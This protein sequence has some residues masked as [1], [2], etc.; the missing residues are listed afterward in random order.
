MREIILIS[1]LGPDQPN[2][3]TRLMQ[4]LSV[5]SLQILDVGQAVIHNQ[6]TL[7][8]VVASENE[9]AT[10]LVMKEIL[11]LAH[12]IGLTVRFKPIS[13]AEYDQWVSEGGRTRYIVTALAPELT[14]AHL[15]AVTQIVSSQGFN[16]ET[17]TRLSGRVDLEKDSTLPRR[18]CVQF[19]LSSGPTLDAQAMR[20]A[21][22]LLSSELNIDVAVQED[23]AYRR[24]R[25][26]VCFD[27]DSTLIEQ[28]VIDELALEAGVGEQVAEIT[29]RA[30]QG[31][32]DF[33]Q[34]FRARVALLKGLDAS[35]LPKIAERLTITEG[36]E[37]LISTLKAL[38][39]KTAILSGGFQ[40]FAEYLQAK[41]GIDEVHANVLD[42][43]DGVVTG[44]VKG[45]IVD[46]ARKA[47]LLRELANKLG[48]SLEQAMAVGDGANDLPM[49]AIAG[50]GVA[51]RAKPLV[52][53]NANQ[54]ISS[55]GLDGVL[56]LLGMHDKDLSR[57]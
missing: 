14:A 44:E 43:Q 35:V 47:E 28:E 57:A 32:L 30:M 12:D 49:L 45:V 13:G 11:I 7:G 41:L 9:T 51:Y 25:R 54:A 29:E 5:H 18:A 24:N 36:A 8:I 55:V 46:G 38:G 50:L 15:Q 20:A 40:Y 31:E 56:Y 39:Y 37:R 10:A 33:Q 27:M 16:I 22:L 6:L 48:I 3:F 53:Q 19:G 2:Q 17:V 21:C 52:R 4:V 1:F 23:N 42:V 26:L 34:S